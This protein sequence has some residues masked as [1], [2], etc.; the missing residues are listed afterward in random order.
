V[1]YDIQFTHRAGKEFLSL[2][3][4]IKARVTERIDAL[5]LDPPP[6]GCV[7]VQGFKGAYRLRV[8]DYRVA[9]VVEDA[10]YDVS[11]VRMG[12]RRE[13]YRNL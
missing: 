5:H 12:H 1:V 8:G 9:Y 11:V 13:I 2:P 6:S 7:T 4:E 3:A 10:T